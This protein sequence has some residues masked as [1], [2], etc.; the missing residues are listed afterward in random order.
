MSQYETT[1][2][3]QTTTSD[4]HPTLDTKAAA[5]LSDVLRA[6]EDGERGYR[7][8]ASDV[9]DPGYQLIFTRD[10]K[11]RAAFAAALRQV[12][13]PDASALVCDG[14]ALGALHRGWLDAKSAVTGGKPKAVLAECQRGEDRALELYRAALHADLHPELRETVQEQYEAIKKARAELAG[15][16]EADAP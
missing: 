7:A 3:S 15:L 13:L 12:V 2:D 9:T 10:A 16:R 5:A 4:E 14:S 6:C 1:H 8:A 11:E